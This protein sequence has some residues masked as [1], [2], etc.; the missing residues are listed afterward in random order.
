M[1][2]DIEIPITDERRRARGAV[3]NQSG[4]FEPYQTVDVHD[5]WEIDEDRAVFR[6]ETTFEQA[7]SIIT[8]N[9]S[10]D[11]PFDR[12]IN[13]YRGCEHGCIYC[14]ARPTHSYLGLSAG[15]DFETRLVAKPNA[16]ERLAQELRRRG[17]AVAPIAI[18]TNTDPYQPIEAKHGIMRE[19]LK[20]LLE[21]K[22]PVTIVTKGTLIERDL[23]I[24]TELAKLQLVQVGISLTSLDNR[25]SRL[26]EPRAPVPARRLRAM[27]ALTKAGVPVRAMIAPVVPCITDHELERLIGASVGAGAQAISWI[28]LRLP[29]EVSELFQEWLSA[30]FPDR[31]SKVLSHIKDMH[32]GKLYDAEWGKRMRGEGHY[33][34]L[35][36]HRAALAMRRHKVSKD[37][38]KLQTDLFEVPFAEGNQLSLF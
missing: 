37:L 28:L 16:P 35:I 10:P 17:Y 27:E 22:H 33:A 1:P 7:K 6:T 38:P 18:G 34:D 3:T 24:L 2:N 5:G 31:K 4:R 14:F 32:G 30:H 25:V 15:L 26:M 21:F 19:C 12:S 13:M 20:V 11:I 23:D 36:A 29:L 8:R 9:T